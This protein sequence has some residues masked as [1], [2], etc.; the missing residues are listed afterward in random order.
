MSL[1]L[2]E[3]KEKHDKAYTSSQV[4]RERAA[5]DLVFFWITQWDDN[6]LAESQLAY[7]GEFN[8][9]RKAG[10]GI[11]SD[12]AA[13]PVQVDFEPKDESRE[14][15]AELLDGLYRS[16]DNSNTSINAYE[17]A[18]TESVVCGVG[19]WLL[20]TD[21]ASIKSEDD[22]NQVIK[23]KP[24]Y[25]ANNTCFFDP[26][27]KL[28]DKS[29]ANYVSVLSAYSADGY[30]QLV[31][32]LTGEELDDII[33]DSF[34]SPE[35]SY[36][37]PWLGGEMAKIYVTEFYHR[38]KVKVKV[39]TMLNPVGQE[40]TLKESDLFD[41]MDDMINTG[42]SIVSEKT[43]TMWQI[44]KYI[45]SGAEILNGKMGSDGERMGEPIAG[46]N[47]PVVPVYGEYAIVEGE[48][49]HEGV[50]R[51]AKDPSRLRNFQGS[52]LADIV[53]QSPRQKPIFYKEQI[54]GFEPMYELNGVDNNYPY[55]LQNRIAGDGSTLPIG[56]VGLMPEQKI[57]DALIASLL[58]SR[59][60][61]EDVAN[62]G[63]PQ[64]VADPNISGKAVHA[65]QNR[66]DMQSMVYQ[67]HM[68]HAKRRDGEI[69]ASMAAEIY[70]VPR[71]V[72]ITLPDGTRKKTQVM[73][74]VIDQESGEIVTL[75]DIYNQ[76][77]DVYSDISPTYSSRKE[78]TVDRLAQQVSL[79]PPG[80]PLR[81]ILLLKLLK[82]M[83]GVDFDDV[84]DYAN[85]QLVV[86]G[87]KEP[88]TPEEEQAL[89]EAQQGSDE[90][91]PEMLLAM[92]EN[93]KG[94][95]AIMAQKI[96]AI[97]MQAEGSKN[98]A[99]LNIDA[100]E[101]QTDRMKAQIE[102]QK[103]EAEIQY[104]R[105]DALGKQIENAGKIVE[106]RQPKDMNDND[107]LMELM[108]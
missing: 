27:A 24:I 61:V 30:K 1:T 74:T 58:F 60:A 102:A 86:L 2:K 98:K 32:D 81:N 52:Y 82:L 77:F 44:T 107:L 57:P 99:A 88:E 36:V 43:I 26:N 45:A 73:D 103:A 40:I 92:G 17:N 97:K 89:A 35:Q 69:Y 55:L 28:L 47:I 70:D 34:K 72:T 29:E 105:I 4:T 5:D 100:F 63:I 59:E 20:Y 64:D 62:P 84:R 50:T 68:K 66:V 22:N 108:G 51:L 65:L 67:E 9:L 39:L 14:D 13:N 15:G 48:I 85:K 106:L 56:P 6:I 76:E 71:R 46:E 96:S 11:L 7:R 87:I 38:E 23:R 53:S 12:L 41:V 49:H 10:R 8:I 25:E 94:D 18:R 90:P 79:L 83:D 42:F 16:D 19:A 95:A 104:K 91:S 21:Y 37:F 101:A 80:D 75:N 3:L 54:A 93:K 78:Q 31:K 33:Y